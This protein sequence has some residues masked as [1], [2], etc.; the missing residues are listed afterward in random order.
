MMK[1]E[2]AP[3]ARL[4]KMPLGKVTIQVIRARRVLHVLIDLDV[5]L[6][7]AAAFERMNGAEGRTRLRDA[8]I[9]AVSDISETALWYVDGGEV[10]VSNEELAERIAFKLNRKFEEVRHVE[11][12]T[13]TLSESLRN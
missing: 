4:F 7:G 9:E 5:Y 12:L 2:A 8:T 11:I 1:P 6:E 10:R 3:Q 13:L